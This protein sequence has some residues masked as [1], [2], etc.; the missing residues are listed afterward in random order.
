MAKQRKTREAG[1]RR[2]IVVTD[3]E[4]DNECLISVA[5]VCR[6]L[7]NCSKM[8]LWRLLHDQSYAHLKFPRPLA[9]GKV[10]RHER[11]FFRLGEV[12][13]W[14]IAR[15]ALSTQQPIAA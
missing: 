3:G 8:H 2:R 7:G 13:A 1:S 5:D 12:R 15:A 14:I 11:K 4:L 9:I 10:G 6:L